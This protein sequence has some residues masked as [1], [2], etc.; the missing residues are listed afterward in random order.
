MQ[1]PILVTHD[2][3]AIV[4]LEKTTCYNEQELTDKNDNSFYKLK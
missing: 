2:A 3:D 1:L 4:T